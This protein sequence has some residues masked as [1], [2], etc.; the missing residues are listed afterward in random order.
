MKREKSKMVY[1]IPDV[2]YAE[3]KCPYH[4]DRLA[5]REDRK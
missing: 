5:E 4:Q 3:I 1:K 2:L